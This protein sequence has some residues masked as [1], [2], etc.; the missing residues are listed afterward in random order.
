[1]RSR[2]SSSNS[3]FFRS[4]FGRALLSRAFVSE[5]A[6]SLNL[7]LNSSW[8]AWDMA[9]VS[10]KQFN[11]AMANSEVI[12]SRKDTEEPMG[13]MTKGSFKLNHHRGRKA[14]KVCV[15][16]SSAIQP[17]VSDARRG[18]LQEPFG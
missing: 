3:S 12:W 6:A 2:R 13:F 1:M 11:V 18:R 17:A 10:A 8:F 4:D 14:L 9:S 16:V 7:P 15:L 5:A